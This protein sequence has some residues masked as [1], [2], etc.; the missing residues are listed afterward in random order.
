MKRI[1][2]MVLILSIIISSLSGCKKED[3]AATLHVGEWLHMV[4]EAFGMYSYNQEEPYFKN[5]TAKNDYFTD[6]QI[7][8][9]W[10]IIETDKEKIDLEEAVTNNFLAITLVN[11]ANLS[12]NGTVSI[13]NPS[14]VDEPEK[15]VIAIENGIFILHDNEE[16][17]AGAIAD[18]NTARIALEKSVFLWADRTY[19]ETKVDYTAKEGVIDLSKGVFEPEDYQYD[20]VNNTV[21]IP[22]EYVEGM[23]PGDVYI[24]PATDSNPVET[25]CKVENVTFK[26]GN[27]IIKNID[28]EVNSEEVFEELHVQSTYQ[29]K[30][31]ELN[32]L[33]GNG[34]PI[35]WVQSASTM[36]S[37]KKVYEISD[38]VTG[39]EQMLAKQ[40]GVSGKLS[41]NYEGMTISGEISDNSISFKIKGSVYKDKNFDIMVDT[42]GEVSDIKATCEYDY[43]H[44]KLHSATAKVGFK[45]KQK[46]GATVSTKATGVFAPDYSNGN[47]KFGTNFL[48]AVYKDKTAKGA[49]SVKI[50]S[51]PVAGAGVLSWN[52]DVNLNISMSGSVS[53]VVTKSNNYGIEYRNNNIRYIKETNT[54][55]DANAKATIEGCLYIGTSVSILKVK[56]VGVGI[57]AGVGVEG[58]V[59]AH[60]VDIHN[61]LQDELTT[62]NG[63][64]LLANL[65]NLNLRSTD[66]SKIQLHVDLCEEVVTYGIL[67]FKLDTNTALYKVLSKANLKDSNGKSIEFEIS[68]LGKDNCPLHQPFH[69][70]D[71]RLVDKCTRKYDIKPSPTLA[72]SPTIVPTD[73]PTETDNNTAGVAEEGALGDDVLRKTEKADAS[74]VIIGNRLDIESYFINVSVGSTTKVNLIQVPEGYDMNEINFMVNDSSVATIDSSGLVTGVAEGTTLITISTSDG[75][76]SIETAVSVYDEKKKQTIVPTT[77]II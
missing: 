17:E 40:T 56:L 15:V 47:G 62:S 58:E 23:E 44:F 51:F 60:L 57:E 4:N 41:F 45:T 71:G 53:V 43:S 33:D 63:D 27:A 21:V 73:T 46:V 59:T 20:A 76:Y 42:S 19:E 29:P 2:S 64:I 8:V 1:I 25:A 11:A 70:E 12:G 9:E 61:V 28:Q 35:T 38:L 14:Q 16:F 3:N 37:R 39:K 49:K 72:V 24:I 77:Y 10:N 22:E 26:D 30:L 67:N 13:T 54:D 48:R 32:V 75:K 50:C 7:A 69:W 74:N 36:D 31:S 52:L 6:V 18:P 5:V 65:D 55:I 68:L 34:N 66:S